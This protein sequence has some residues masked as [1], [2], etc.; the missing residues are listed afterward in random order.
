MRT[1]LTEHQYIV[2]QMAYQCHTLRRISLGIVYGKYIRPDDQECTVYAKLRD[3]NRGAQRGIYEIPPELEMPLF[4]EDGH[5][6]SY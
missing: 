1:P 4:Q 6:G 5:H 2:L 3:I